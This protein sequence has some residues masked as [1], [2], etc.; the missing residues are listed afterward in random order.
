MFARRT[1]NN[2]TPDPTQSDET[3]EVRATVVRPSAVVR[4]T[5]AASARSVSDRLEQVRNRVRSSTLRDFW[6]ELTS[7]DEY[8]ISYEAVRNYHGDRDPPVDYLVRVSDVF[9]VNLPW[10]ATGRG[11]PWPNDPEIGRR[12][13]GAISKEPAAEFEPALSE[14]FWHYEALTSVAKAVALE[15]CD[16]LHRDAEFRARLNGRTAPTRAYVGRFVGKAMAGP[17][18]NAV[19]GSVQTSDL[20][21]WQIESFVLGICQALSA[22]IPNPNWS[23]QQLRHDLH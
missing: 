5:R 21:P 23:S 9:H 1:P 19:A 17:L 22:L 6:R 7:D 14:V 10:L 2:G 8:R 4:R 12:A 3:E 13:E 11:H 18:R 16:R 20:H 15:T